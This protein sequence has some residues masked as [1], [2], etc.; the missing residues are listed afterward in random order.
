MQIQHTCMLMNHPAPVCRGAEAPTKDSGTNWCWQGRIQPFLHCSSLRGQTQPWKGA[1]TP[2]SRF[3]TPEQA[4]GCGRDGMEQVAEPPS[5]P[6]CC[7]PLTLGASAPHSNPVV[8]MKSLSVTWKPRRKE[9]S[10][11][12]LMVLLQA[13]ASNVAASG[14]SPGG[15]GSWWHGELASVSRGDGGTGS[16]W[17]R[18]MVSQGDGGKGSW[19]HGE[20]VAQGAGVTGRWWHREMVAQAEL[21]MQ[22]RGLLRGGP[23]ILPFVSLFNLTGQT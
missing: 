17:H 12:K 16:W 8:W 18:E 6:L 10:S 3:Q 19:C 13:A 11:L 9:G 1:P 14:C 4:G 5:A 7:S 2:G 15:T 21:L 22:E 23:R 20:I